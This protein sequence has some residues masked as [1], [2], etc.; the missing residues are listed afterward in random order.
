APMWR[1]AL[2]G[3]TVERRGQF[4]GKRPRAATLNENMMRREASTLLEKSYVA[5]QRVQ[6]FGAIVQG[7]VHHERAA[8]PAAKADELRIWAIRLVRWDFG[9]SE[10]C[11]GCVVAER[12]Y[13]VARDAK[14]SGQGM[15]TATPVGTR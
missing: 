6:D 14:R 9:D 2:G 7:F 15:L 1:W 12:N 3:Y 10:D 11:E 8:Y 13:L 4:G 5:S